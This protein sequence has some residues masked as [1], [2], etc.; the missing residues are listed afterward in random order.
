MPRQKKLETGAQNNVL[1]RRT[2]LRPPVVKRHTTPRSGF[3]PFFS[4]VLQAQ[5]DPPLATCAVFIAVCGGIRRDGTTH[6]LRV[7]H[8]RDGGDREYW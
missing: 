4:A 6:F 8:H 2:L 5:R 7:C 3:C 1:P